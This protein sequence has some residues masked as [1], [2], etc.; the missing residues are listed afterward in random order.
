MSTRVIYVVHE[1]FRYDDNSFEGLG[2]YVQYRGSQRVKHK[3]RTLKERN[4][5]F[6]SL[7]LILSP[8]ETHFKSEIMKRLV[9]PCRIVVSYFLHLHLLEKQGNEGNTSQYKATNRKLITLK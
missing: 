4:P 7:S 5:N 1:N 3:I 2:V 9:F 6:L 8:L